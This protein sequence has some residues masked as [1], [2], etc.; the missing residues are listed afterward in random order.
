MNTKEFYS[1]EEIQQYYD[2]R[3]NV[4]IFKEN[5]N[6]IDKIIFHFDLNVEA[7]IDARDIEAH[8]INAFDINAYHINATEIRAYNIYAYMI[9]AN[10]VDSCDIKSNFIYVK[11]LKASDISASD[12]IA[13]FISYNAVCYAYKHIKCKYI[14]GLFKFS[15]HFVLLG[16]LEVKD[17][18]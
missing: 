15:Q 18:E 4:Y 10:N 1:L 16:T 2:E 17:D 6:Y 14:E 11:Y 7:N 5:N 12:I 13:D 3:A 9:N 8:Y